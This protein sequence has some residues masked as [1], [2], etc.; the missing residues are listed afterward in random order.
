M[1]NKNNNQRIARNYEILMRRAF[2]CERTKKNGAHQLLFIELY[3][4]EK[5]KQIAIFKTPYNRHFYKIRLY[6][7][8]ALLKLKKRKRYRNSYEQFTPLLLK[9]Q[10]ANTAKDL[11]VIVNG[12]LA[13]I[14][15]LENQLK[16]NNAK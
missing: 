7:E 11:A 12:S 6:I 3:K 13:K 9:L 14:I 16:R 15:K 1:D 10:K 4:K 5:V 2:N 8:K